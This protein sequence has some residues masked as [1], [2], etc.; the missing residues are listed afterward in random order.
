MSKMILM[1]TMED[2]FNSNLVLFNK[3]TSFL[4]D[5]KNDVLIK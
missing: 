2:R 3:N 4:D 1:T 5:Q